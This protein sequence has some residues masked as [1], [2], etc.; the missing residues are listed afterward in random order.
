MHERPFTENLD[1]LRAGDVVV[2]TAPNKSTTIRLV[3]ASA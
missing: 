1:R 3:F 2:R